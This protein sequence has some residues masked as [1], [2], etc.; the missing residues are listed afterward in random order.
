MPP[1][2]KVRASE[3][4]GKKKDQGLTR[5]AILLIVVGGI[6]LYFMFKWNSEKDFDRFEKAKEYSQYYKDF[7]TERPVIY[8]VF[9]EKQLVVRAN[10]LGSKFWNED[11]RAMIRK[12]ENEVNEL[13]HVDNDD[14]FVSIAE[15]LNTPDPKNKNEK[16]LQDL[17]S[18]P[19]I[20]D[21]LKTGKELSEKSLYNI[22][23][24]EIFDFWDKALKIYEA[25]KKIKASINEKIGYL[26]DNT[27]LS[28][29]EIK[30]R[31]SFL[32]TLT[33]EKTETSI[34]KEEL[35]DNILKL[36]D[37]ETAKKLERALKAPSSL[38]E[39]EKKAILL[40]IHRNLKFDKNVD[41]LPDLE[42][43]KSFLPY[44]KPEYIALDEKTRSVKI[45]NINTGV[46]LSFFKDA[47]FLKL[48]QEKLPKENFNYLIYLGGR[49][50]I[51]KL[52]EKYVRWSVSIDDP[53]VVTDKGRGAFKLL[54][55]KGSFVMTQKNEEI[56]FLDME[57]ETGKIRKDIGNLKSDAQKA[58]YFKNLK[59]KYPT[60]EYRLDPVNLTL[61][62]RLDMPVDWRTGMPSDKNLS[63]IVVDEDPVRARM[64]SYS[65]FISD[66]DS[67]KAF[68]NTFPETMY[69]VLGYD[70]KVF[71]PE[72]WKDLYLSREDVERLRVE[73]EN[74]SRGLN[75]DGTVPKKK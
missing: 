28:P 64:L 11:F 68:S 62:R 26:F 7:F 9:E 33:A 38:S 55:E 16:K 13:V 2:R 47:L 59:K 15:L 10:N 74:T 67:F 42:S 21:L 35:T 65:L 50:G 6:F 60:R 23:S 58:E 14:T 30:R 52:P 8:K 12:T 46:K 69:A 61:S 1:R 24:G 36:A 18:Y 5:Y 49:H 70:G 27:T 34:S 22:A 32:K 43:V 25:K 19:V 51:W 73:F 29:Y 48:L 71:V 40:R 45:T 3:L 20:F 37:K 41:V 17:T 63:A 39:S 54:P 75:P 66:K 57:K 53:Y 44:A 31:K 56:I 4:A 72:K